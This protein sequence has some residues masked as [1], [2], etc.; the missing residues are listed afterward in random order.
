MLSGRQL[1]V[2]KR[3]TSEKEFDNHHLN[4]IG[5]LFVCL[6]SCSARFG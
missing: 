2:G 6:C 3:G 1:A 5:G 4:S